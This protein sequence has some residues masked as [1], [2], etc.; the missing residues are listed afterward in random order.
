MPGGHSDDIKFAGDVPFHSSE[1]RKMTYVDLRKNEIPSRNFDRNFYR[2]QKKMMIGERNQ[3]PKISLEAYTKEI[4]ADRTKALCRE[5]FWLDFKAIGSFP[6]EKSFDVDSFLM[7]CNDLKLKGPALIVQFCPVFMAENIKTTA[8]LLNGKVTDPSKLCFFKFAMF[9]PCNIFTAFICFPY[10]PRSVMSFEISKVFYNKCLIP[11]LK[12]TK[13]DCQRWGENMDQMMKKC[14][15][16]A[17]TLGMKS[18]ALQAFEICSLVKELRKKV[19]NV[20]EFDFKDFFFHVCSKGIKGTTKSL[21]VEDSVKKFF[22]LQG[23]CF[24]LSG[25]YYLDIAVEY[26][27]KTDGHSLVFKREFCEALADNFE[28]S[29]KIVKDNFSQS[30]EL[31]GIRIHTKQSICKESGIQF[32]QCYSVDKEILCRKYDTAVSFDYGYH[33]QPKIDKICQ[34]GL[35]MMRASREKAFGCR[36]EF[37]ILNSTIMALFDGIRILTDFIDENEMIAC[38]KNSCIM[39]YRE[40]KLF[41]YCSLMKSAIKT[42]IERGKNHQRTNFILLMQILI[43]SLF[44]RIDE[45]SLTKSLITMNAD[46]QMVDKIPIATV[47]K[48]YNCFLLPGIALLMEGS[49]VSFEDYT[50]TDSSL[51]TR[52]DEAFSRAPK[53]YFS[54][55]DPLESSDIKALAKSVLSSKACVNSTAALHCWVNADLKLL[56]YTICSNFQRDIINLFPNKWFRIKPVLLKAYY[57]TNQ[58]QLFKFSI[59]ND[60]KRLFNIMFHPKKKT[61]RWTKT[62]YFAMYTYICQKLSPKQVCKLNELIF[63]IIIDQ[64][65]TF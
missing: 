25:E 8:F 27:P 52:I 44:S 29:S 38:L 50:L 43:K 46:N 54:E 19:G 65:D 55:S 48:K 61:V 14:R 10:L 30:H 47:I 12:R 45:N 39:D 59:P 7:N 28:N 63:D 33:S 36:M 13:I 21:N 5:D 32:L 34:E 41:A 40:S 62:K 58:P 15:S 22:S 57:F 2:I 11:C 6:Y 49:T 17:G 64:T 23:E 18:I 31:G 56:A 16:A 42:T 3:L 24:Q 37:R 51:E 9:G 53:G 1:K 20:T 4:K 26:V 60:W 35:D